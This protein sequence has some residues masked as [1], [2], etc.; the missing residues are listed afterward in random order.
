[1]GSL[2]CKSSSPFN[3]KSSLL[4]ARSS[5]NNPFN[6]GV[7]TNNIILC[8]IGTLISLKFKIRRLLES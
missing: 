4:D 2:D 6:H 7:M 8:Q 3:I 5:P 1:L